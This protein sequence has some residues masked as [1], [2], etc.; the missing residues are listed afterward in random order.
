[1]GVL[2]QFVGDPGQILSCGDAADWPGKDVVEHQCGNRELGQGAAQGFLDHAV[3][4]AA[5]EHTAALDVDRANRI[6]EQHD[7]EDE[8]GSGLA[9]EVLCFTARVIR[10]GSQVVQD[11]R[12]G[13]PVG[14]EGQHGRRS[15]N[16]L[17]GGTNN[18]LTRW[19]LGISCHQF[20]RCGVKT[21]QT[22]NRKGKLH[23]RDR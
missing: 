12:G 16:D 20:T 2:Q 8:P 4:A 19:D 14:N 23:L 6:A 5:H 9:D 15:H 13:T 22:M 1:M 3:H 21:I 7:G 11:D 17:G 10:R 18:V